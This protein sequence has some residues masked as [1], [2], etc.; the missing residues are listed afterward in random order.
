MS[1]AAGLSPAACAALP[2]WK[3]LLDLSLIILVLPV[4]GP[5]LLVI[6]VGIKIVS[7]G[8][9]LFRQPRIGYRGTPFL[10]FKFR[11]MRAD[12]SKRVHE[13]YFKELMRSERPMT[14]LDSY[15]DERLI[16]LGALLRSSA[17]D[18]LPQL[19]NVLKGEMSLVGP[20]PCTPSEYDAY[21]PWEKERFAAIPGLTGLWQV[22]GKNRTTF[23]EMILL[24][25]EYA[26]QCSFLLDLRIIF[27]TIPVLLVEVQEMLKRRWAGRKE[28][29]TDQPKRNVPTSTNGFGAHALPGGSRALDGAQT[30]N[31]AG[32]PSNGTKP[33]ST[34]N[35][36]RKT[37]SPATDRAQL[38]ADL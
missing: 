35:G 21:L 38:R 4:L 26:R 17:L 8:P 25:I 13:D 30:Q 18:E 9:I 27:K 15:N 20:R 36:R 16:P 29:Q 37:H 12:A 14:K 34:A 28:Q 31:G 6:A 33:R 23:E 22:S 3:R 10:C 11:S 2:L 5:L 19:F 24:D 1:G 32:S 7:K